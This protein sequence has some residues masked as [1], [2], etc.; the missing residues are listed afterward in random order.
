MFRCVMLHF[1][2]AL[3]DF[4]EKLGQRAV[5]ICPPANLRAAYENNFSCS[6]HHPSWAIIIFFLSHGRLSMGFQRQP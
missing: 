2:G 1:T 4:L 5:G 6:P 3:H